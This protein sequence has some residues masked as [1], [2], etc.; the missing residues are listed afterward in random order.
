[1]TSLFVARPLSSLCAASPLVS[2]Y[3]VRTLF[4]LYAVHRLS[5]ICVVR[6]VLSLRLVR[7][8]ILRFYYM[9][10]MCKV[11][12]EHILKFICFYGLNM[13]STWATNTLCCC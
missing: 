6:P 9:D 7:P 11:C 10:V 2:S 3:V 5:S 8:L 4:S 12:V 13:L 1:M